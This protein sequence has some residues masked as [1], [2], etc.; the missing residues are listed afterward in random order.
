MQEFSIFF[1]IF[2]IFR[3]RAII[4]VRVITY[5]SFLLKSL[6]SPKN[7]LTFHL[8]YMHVC[9]YVNVCL[10]MRV[11]C[12]IHILLKYANFFEEKCKKSSFCK[13]ELAK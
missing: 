7:R 4:F 10:C 13:V 2:C 6:K 8:L 5:T 9:I 11:N 1:Y 3:F 12:K